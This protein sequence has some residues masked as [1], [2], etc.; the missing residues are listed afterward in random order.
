M[1]RHYYEFPNDVLL[2]AA[3]SGDQEAR[4]ERLI[5]EIM[6]VRNISWDEAQVR[7]EGMLL[8]AVCAACPALPANALP[9]LPPP[10]PEF[11]KIVACNR[12]GLFLNTLPYK[13]GIASALV[14]GFASIPMI[15]E[16]NT[17]LWFNE[18]E[19]S[20]R[21]VPACVRPTN[22]RAITLTASPSPHNACSLRDDG[23]A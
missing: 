12:E 18:G 20:A 15:F 22:R 16:L 14:M 4:E 11:A 19:C 5:R 17:V 21:R 6:H 1:P 13:L 9:R 23:R 8:C 2:S 3:L 10:Q 7:R